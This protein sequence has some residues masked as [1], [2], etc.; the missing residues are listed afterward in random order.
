MFRKCMLLLLILSLLTGWTSSAQAGLDSEELYAAA[1]EEL[2]RSFNGENRR[3]MSEICEDF[4]SL[5]HYRDSLSFLYYTSVLRDLEAEEFAWIDLYMTLLRMDADFDDTLDARGLPTMGELEAY[6]RGRKAEAEGH[7]QNAI[8]YYQQCGAMLDSLLRVRTLLMAGPVSNSGTS[9][10]QTVPSSDLPPELIPVVTRENLLT[11]DYQITT[12]NNGT[13]EITQYGG[14]DAHLQIP[15]TLNGHT[16]IGIGDDVFAVRY[17]IQTVTL[18]DTITFIDENAF[19]LCRYMT[20]I[21]IPEG[22]VRIG[23]KAFNDCDAVSVFRI[24]ASVAS[25]GEDAFTACSGLITF[26]VSPENPYFDSEKDALIDRNGRLLAY[27]TASPTADY[28]IPAG[29]TAIGTSAFYG[30]Y[31]LRNVTIPEGVL[32]IEEMAFMYCFYMESLTLPRSVQYIGAD[33]FRSCPELTLRVPTGSYAE[34]YAR[35][36]KIPYVTVP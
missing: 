13:C 33:A 36:N 20:S 21:N 5:G 16:V 28:S 8:T 6:A 22:V 26:E 27:A 11:G 3:S 12:Y 35:E 17:D 4:E 1:R 30:T 32:S 34:R 14:F 31:A 29:V 18:P 15:D 24:P 7:A 9:V 25:I 2:I 23:A 19:L 10:N